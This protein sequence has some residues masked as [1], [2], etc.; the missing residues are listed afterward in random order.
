M[1]AG[2]GPMPKGPSRDIIDRQCGSTTGSITGLRIVP[3]DTGLFVLILCVLAQ[4]RQ[5]DFQCLQNHNTLANFLPVSYSQE[6]RT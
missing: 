3:R 1:T 4:S 5:L 2:D 6:A